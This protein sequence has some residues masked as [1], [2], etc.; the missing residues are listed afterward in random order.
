M[1]SGSFQPITHTTTSGGSVSSR[2][3]KIRVNQPLKSQSRATGRGYENTQ[4]SK[5]SSGVPSTSTADARR[6]LFS[7]NSAALPSQAHWGLNSG[8]RYT[9]THTPIKSLFNTNI[10]T[11][12]LTILLCIDCRQREGTR[13]LFAAGGFWKLGWTQ[14]PSNARRKWCY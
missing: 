9:L 14:N 7:G 3:G 8:L 13:Q 1:T 6:A 5:M 4:T 12:T 2:G 10:N 11:S